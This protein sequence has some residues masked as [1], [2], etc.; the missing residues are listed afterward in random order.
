MVLI[1]PLAMT[2]CKEEKITVDGDGE[3]TYDEIVVSLY[4]NEDWGFGIN[5]SLDTLI[6]VYAK[7][8]DPKFA[9]FV[10]KDDGEVKSISFYTRNK[11]QN[12]GKIY[13]ND[14]FDEDSIYDLL[15]EEDVKVALKELSKAG[16]TLEELKTF[17]TGNY[18]SRILGVK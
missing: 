17:A 5:S 12:S 8:G 4:Y 16:L 14:N 7:G 15:P 9:V 1:I 11:S 6:E 2:G 3:R 13:E 10:N 18:R